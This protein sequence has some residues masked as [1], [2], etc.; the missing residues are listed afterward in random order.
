MYLQQSKVSTCIPRVNTHFGGG[1]WAP[2]LV[3]KVNLSDWHGMLDYNLSTSI[4]VCVA[5]YCCISHTLL[6]AGMT[7]HTK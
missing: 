6:F 3:A 2:P 4:D 7:A 5:V 1:P